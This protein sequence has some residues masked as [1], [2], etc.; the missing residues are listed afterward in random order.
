MTHELDTMALARLLARLSGYLVL[1]LDAQGRVLASAA[2]PDTPAGTGAW[3]GQPWAN[4]VT[5]E[6]RP[7][8]GKMLRELEMTGT[9]RRRELN[10]PL[11]AGRSHPMAYHA[12]RLGDGLSLAMGR[13]LG[14]QALM[15]QRLLQAQHEAQASHWPGSVA[16]G[17]VAGK[18]LRTCGK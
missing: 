15:Q 16:G 6:S 5:V 4:T 13:D 1:V 8:V 12:V 17:S 11:E 3:E 2:G 18:S 10:H 9:A 7:K 14:E